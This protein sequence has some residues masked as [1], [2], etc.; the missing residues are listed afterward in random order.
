MNQAFITGLPRTRTY[1]FSRVLD[2]THGVRAYHELLNHC[3]SKEDFSTLMRPVSDQ[4]VV[5]CDS[6]L[7][8]TDF[9]ERFPDAPIVYIRRNMVDVYY[10]LRSFMP[11]HGVQPNLR[12]LAAM[13]DT[14]EQFYERMALSDRVLTVEFEDLNMYKNMSAISEHLGLQ[15]TNFQHEYRDTEGCN[16]PVLAGNSAAYRVWEEE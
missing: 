1:W 7:Y 13:L 9:L 6:G 8:I 11:S 2:A 5:N 3:T 10:S 14:A 15:D 12:K 4:L 16:M